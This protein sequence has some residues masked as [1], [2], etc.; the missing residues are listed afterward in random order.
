MDDREARPAG[1]AR[2]T[3]IAGESARE[4]A[5][6]S[7]GSSSS[8]ASVCGWAGHTLASGEGS[9][10]DRSAPSTRDTRLA[11]RTR[12]PPAN[13]SYA[14]PRSLMI[15][16]ESRPRTG[17]ARLGRAEAQG[18]ASER[19]AS[20]AAAARWSGRKTTEGL[21]CGHR[22][23]P[24]RQVDGPGASHTAPLRAGE[25]VH[26]PDRAEGAFSRRQPARCVCVRVFEGRLACLRTSIG[27]VASVVQ[28]SLSTSTARTR[29][30]RGTR[31]L[32]RET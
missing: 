30:G 26:G 2:T 12:R 23:H 6:G 31:K 9:T 29:A 3:A 11:H 32:A 18:R 14:P 21:G 15:G 19:C 27:L 28:P 25:G 13:L 24:P 16:A 4:S 17:R 7:D 20:A 22:A 5:G 8:P 1:R 10:L